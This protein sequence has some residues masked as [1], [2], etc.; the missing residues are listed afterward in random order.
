M[1]IARKACSRTPAS[2]VWKAWS[3]GPPRGRRRRAQLTQGQG[4]VQLN[5]SA[6]VFE[7]PPAEA[8]NNGRCGAGQP[9]KHPDGF[10]LYLVIRILQQG[11]QPTQVDCTH[12]APL[13]H[14]L[15]GRGAHQGV[16]V[17]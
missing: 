7:Q 3:K 6:I 10:D 15:N 5:P 12:V 9:R 2:P 13:A 16:G 11:H 14:R 8:V 17:L 4:G 1:A